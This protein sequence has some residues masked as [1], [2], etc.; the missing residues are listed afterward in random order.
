[1]SIDL[2]YA[3]IAAGL[4]L[5]GCQS[6]PTVAPQT[7]AVRSTEPQ[8][9]FERER[10]ARA[11]ALTR[12]GRFGEALIEWEI[13]ALFNAGEPSYREER[14]RARAAAR[15]GANA[16]LGR[17]RKALE[18]GDERQAGEQLLLALSLEPGN[19]DA[20]RGLR[21]LERTLN[22]RH[23]L[24]RP[25][26]LTMGRNNGYAGSPR[27]AVQEESPEP[28]TPLVDR[29]ATAGI[30]RAEREHAAMLIRAGEF[31]EA[32]AML[33][34]LVKANPDDLDARNAL[35]RAWA[36]FGDDALGKGRPRA[37]LRAFRRAASYLYPNDPELADKIDALAKS[38]GPG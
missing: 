36:S 12:A 26:R 32:L 37:A 2:R 19:I 25:S 10:L 7:E 14:E 30:E 29:G 27:P 38:L 5:C 4:A 16:H 1:M 11:R 17:A 33:A 23:F 6:A 35:G 28:E 34:R 21:E 18:A 24:G 15:N 13:L 8:A 31:T 3:L 22:R 20:A 9:G